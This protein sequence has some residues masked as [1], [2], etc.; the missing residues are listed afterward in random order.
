MSILEEAG[1]Q[2]QQAAEGQETSRNVEGRTQWQLT[3]RRLRPRTK[4]AVVAVCGVLLPV[5]NLV[6]MTL[7]FRVKPA[8]KLPM[9]PSLAV[10]QQP[11]RCCLR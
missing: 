4:F 11:W 7:R 5:S 3:W 10:A 8:A 6:P 2:A 1:Q 9:I